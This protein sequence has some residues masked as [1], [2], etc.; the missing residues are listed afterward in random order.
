MIQRT[1][2]SPTHENKLVNKIADT[3]RTMFSAVEVDGGQYVVLEFGMPDEEGN[4]TQGGNYLAQ[5]DLPF[6][7][8]KDGIK[9]NPDEIFLD[10]SQEN[11][12]RFTTRELCEEYINSLAEFRLTAGDF[13]PELAGFI[14]QCLDEKS[15]IDEV[16]QLPL[17]TGFVNCE[18]CE[19]YDNC[20]N[21]GYCPHENGF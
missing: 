17:P 16:E 4:L 5:Y 21:T 20:M 3:L 9:I 2:T 1:E 14:K 7:T 15:N 11:A 19:L 18:Q 13:P 12:T 6:V 8:D 10:T